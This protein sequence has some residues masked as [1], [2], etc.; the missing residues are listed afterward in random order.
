MRT[1]L[2]LSVSAFLLPAFSLAVEYQ[3]DERVAADSAEEAGVGL[4]AID[5][6]PETRPSRTLLRDQFT[7]LPPFWRDSEMDFKIRAFDLDRED[8]QITTREAFAVGSELTFRSGKLAE[9]LSAV[10]SW[11]TSI[12]INAPADRGQTGLLAPD[13]SDLSVLSRAHLQFELSDS[14]SLRAYRQDFS[15][16]YIN[17]QDSRMIPNTFEAYMLRLAGERLQWIA[18]QVTR[19]KRRDSERFVAMGEIAGAP[20]SDAGTTVL[21]AR[22]I[23]HESLTVG[24]VVQS[25]RNLFTTTYS[26]ISWKRTL[27][28][29]WGLQAAGQYTYQSSTG[30][31]LLGDFSTEHWGLRGVVSYRGA[32]LTTA[33][34]RT[35]DAEIR[36][37][38]GGTPAFT[39]SMLYDFDRAN[40]SAFRFGISQ[41]LARIGL[42]GT[43]VK[44]DLTRGSDARSDAD[45]PLPDHQELAL[46]LD[47]RPD[48]GLFRGAWIRVRYSHGNR[49]TPADDRRELRLIL[50]YNVEAWR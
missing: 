11:H 49:D 26:E 37:P 7:D 50:N 9:R 27:N 48:R 22:Y 19:M 12:G 36:K 10:V 41:N 42:E 4:E 30:D 1:R 21:G 44:F 39:S 25:T 18:G 16:P 13:Q 29:N 3:Q 20:G 5:A 6:A 43:N 35:G 28:E 47:F 2:I 17:R 32:V 46:T 40:E 38:F 31:E 45:S 14:L 8:S 23:P 15:M 34:S 24:A 33:Y